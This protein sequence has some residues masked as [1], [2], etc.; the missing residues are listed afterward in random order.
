[1]GATSPEF[2]MEL[3][4]LVK[5]ARPIYLVLTRLSLS[6]SV[7]DIIQSVLPYTFTRSIRLF[8]NTSSRKLIPVFNVSPTSRRCRIF[9]HG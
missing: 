5:K 8:Y 1:M 2:R 6:S 7:S 9:K 4:D 3:P